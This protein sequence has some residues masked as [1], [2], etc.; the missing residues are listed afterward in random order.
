MKAIVVEDSRLAREG[1]IRML[2]QHRS[3]QIVG[4]AEHPEAARHLIEKTQPE[5]LFLDIH[6]PGETGFDLLESL[7]Y[8]PKIIFTTAYSDYA[9][10][11]FDY[12]TV[13][14][15]LKPISEERLATAITKLTQQSD[16]E[17]VDTNE[18]RLDVRS[19][20]FVKEGGKY[21]LIDVASILYVESN[22]NYVNIVLGDNS[23]GIKRSLNQI[24]ARL[25]ERLFF[26]ISRKHLVNLQEVEKIDEKS[27]E[28]YNITL[29]N[30]E[31]LEVSKRNA[32]KLKAA[33]SL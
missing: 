14:Y 6:M 10:R 2:K 3:I 25:P 21:H 8:A 28:G 19:R 12:Q 9:I 5:L 23:V 33:L 18:P 32:V 27:G 26:R 11:S 24:E 30:G 29:S 15:L 1:L 20:V 17:E 31:E 4:D 7:D 16:S 22:R 13:D